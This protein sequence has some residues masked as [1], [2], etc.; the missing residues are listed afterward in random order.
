MYLSGT[1]TKPPP[2]IEFSIDNDRFLKLG[3]IPAGELAEE[4][5]TVNFI[6]TDRTDFIE[7]A[8]VFAAGDNS[9][10]SQI[11]VPADPAQFGGDNALAYVLEKSI[12]NV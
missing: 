7:L 6:S 3:H 4:N 11:T 5:G 8:I 2:M 10:I 9:G 12:A 1:I